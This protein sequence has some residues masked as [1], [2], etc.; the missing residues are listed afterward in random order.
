MAEVWQKLSGERQRGQVLVG[1][2]M[3]AKGI[4][5][6]DVTLVAAIHADSGLYS[7]DF[8]S[9]E[10]TF[11][12]LTQVAGRAGRHDKPGKVFFQTYNP[13]HRVIQQAS[14]YNFADF[15]Q[16]EIEERKEFA[17]PPF[18]SLARYVVSHEKDE[19]ASREANDLAELIKHSLKTSLL[20]LQVLGPAQ[21]QLE[22]I[23]NMNRYHVLL[24]ASSVEALQ[25]LA[26]SLKPSFKS[27]LVF[28]LM[29]ASLL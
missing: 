12:L 20:D 17:F 11:Q 23:N 13:E 6:P 1:T 10:K 16:A 19:T 29:P 28:D 25:T 9:A 14:Q 7:A 5:L 15:A 8:N 24:K 27:R 21:C 3:I 18:V 22:K 26:E 2:Q 4:D